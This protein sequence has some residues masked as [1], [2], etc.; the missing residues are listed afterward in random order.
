[1]IY[2]KLLPGCVWVVSGFSNAIKQQA[3]PENYSAI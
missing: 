1:M 3:F 2:A